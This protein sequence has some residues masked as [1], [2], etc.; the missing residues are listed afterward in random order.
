MYNNTSV[1][2]TNIVVYKYNTNKRLIEKIYIQLM[3]N[4]GTLNYLN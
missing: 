1:I 3:A 4:I 2:R